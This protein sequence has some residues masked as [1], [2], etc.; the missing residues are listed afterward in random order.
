MEIRPRLAHRRGLTPALLAGLVA[1]ASVGAFIAGRA[2]TRPD[3]ANARVVAATTAAS[4]SAH[5]EADARLLGSMVEAIG[6]DPS[7]P[8]DELLANLIRLSVPGRAMGIARATSTTTAMIAVAVP[9]NDRTLAGL[10][11]SRRPL[12]RL[13]LDLARDAGGPEVAAGMGAD[14]RHTVIE[15]MPMFG[16]VDTPVDVGSRRQSLKG[17][18]VMLAPAANDLGLTSSSADAH[19]AVRIVQGDIVLAA[20]GRGANRRPPDSATSVPVSTNGVTWA[21]EAW[22]TAGPSTTPVVELLVGLFLALVV[23]ALAMR[24]ERSIKRAVSEA[25]SRA[26][27]VSLVARAGPLLQQSLALSD[28]LP[29]FAVEISDQLALN[30]VAIDL[31]AEDG[32]LA[33]AFSLG[34]AGA[35][36]GLLADL[37]M[38]S[39][40][41]DAGEVV[42][43]PLLRG[44][45][46]VGVLR[47]RPVKGLSASQVDALVAVCNLL[48]AALGNAR[49]FQDEREMVERLRGVDRMKTT[50]VSSVSHELRTTVTAIEGFAGLLDGDPAAPDD[51]RNEYLERLKRNARSLGVLVDDLLDFARFERASSELALKPVDLSH[52]VPQI[53]DQTSSLLAD[54]PVTMHIAPGVTALADLSAVERILVNL[55]SNASKYTPSGS[56]VE[57]ILEAADGVA[58]MTV[59]DHG[60]GI[61]EDERDNVF[62]LFYRVVDQS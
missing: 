2:A 10:D 43:V 62:G 24:R 55:L 42:S 27:E 48:A 60:P 39:G 47:A 53:V 14:G 13:A 58:V 35:A 52:I 37:V 19:L 8:D 21:V 49:L 54:R 18:V 25:E 61:A 30:A 29:V 33:R 16:T 9:T 40:A 22:S 41:V 23:G 34:P 56:A 7:R 28:V 11:F 1:A 57:V 5:L 12:L 31:V 59:A 46:S 32:R 44:A 3:R 51:P 36:H 17:F 20:A 15:A 45:R 4:L 50:F 6:G 26:Q 38:P